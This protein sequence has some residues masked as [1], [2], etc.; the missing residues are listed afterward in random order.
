MK[1]VLSVVVIL[2][3]ASLVQGADP[4]V[5][6]KQFFGVRLGE[7]VQ[8]V[9]KRCKITAVPD[10][11]NH[12]NVLK[13]WV[14]ENN[15]PTMNIMGLDAF[16]GKVYTITVALKD[17]SD[18]NFNAIKKKLIS[19][20]GEADIELETGAIFRPVIE[21]IN[22]EIG[23]F[24]SK[25]DEKVILMVFMHKDMAVSVNEAIEKAK[26]DKIGDNI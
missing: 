7:S 24:Q 20:Y 14:V 25:N 8:E 1:T 9:G 13:S 2:V 16:K 6:K 26:Q 19:Q 15:N 11:E 18:E 21:G 3:A 22:V 23:I 17:G 4:N 5:V 10:T 12:N